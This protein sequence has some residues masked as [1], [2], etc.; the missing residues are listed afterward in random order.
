MEDCA[1]L[2]KQAA[3]KIVHAKR[4]VTSNIKNGLTNKITMNTKRQS[5]DL[6]GHLSTEHTLKK[7]GKKLK[8]Q[9]DLNTALA[10]E[11]KE[12]ELEHAQRAKSLMRALEEPQTRFLPSRCS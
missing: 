8:R 6:A 5:V 4:T 3:V 1:S 12:T 2:A 11:Q 10:T 7:D 9:A